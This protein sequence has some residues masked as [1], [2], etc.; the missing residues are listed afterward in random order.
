MSIYFIEK[1][2]QQQ[3]VT[4]NDMI[5]RYDAL[6]KK[7]NKLSKENTAL[8]S[9]HDRLLQENHVLKKTTMRKCIKSIFIKYF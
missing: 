8:Q 1:E 5:L 6:S 7:N 9:E 3:N 2:E 4:D